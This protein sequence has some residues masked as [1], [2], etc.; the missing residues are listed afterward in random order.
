MKIIILISLPLM[1]FAQTFSLPQ[2]LDHANKNNKQIKAK[3]FQSKSALN[4]ADAR[5]RDFWPTID[6]GGAYTNTD[7]GTIVAPARTTM[8]YATVKMDLYAGGRKR[9]LLNSKNYL[10]TASLF[11]KTFFEKGVNLNIINY[12]YTVLKIRAI[13]I[14][15]QEQ[16]KELSVQINRMKKFSSAGLATQE[17]VDRLQAE[18][19]NNTFTIESAKLDLL[20]ALQNLALLSGIPAKNLKNNRFL[21]P[22]NISFEPYEKSKILHANAEALGENAKA[23]NAGYLPHVSVEDIYRKSKYSETAGLPG[24][25]RD[26][27][28]PENQN[29]LMLSVN[30]RLFDNNKMRKEREALVYQKLAAD[31]ESVYAVE[32]QMMQYRLARSRMQTIRA[33]GRSAKS[34]LKAATSTHRTIFKKYEAG[35]SDNVTYLDALNKKTLSEAR[36]KEALYDYE[37]SKSIFYFYAGKNIEEYIR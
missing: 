28:L 35:L 36:Y 25:P 33:K 10:Y 16:T 24:L 15:M 9:A 26:G 13:L 23:V 12:Y 19:D 14:A 3:E 5:E 8:G 1:I 18:Y 7:P 32:E 37:I 21:E 30:M 2:L 20:T 6:I 4:E 17:N 31:S 27:F 29:K 34:A 22:K 11:E